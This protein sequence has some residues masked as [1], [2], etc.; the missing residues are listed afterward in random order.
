MEMPDDI[1]ARIGRFQRD[2]DMVRAEITHREL[3]GR[4]TPEWHRLSDEQLATEE[5]WYVKKIDELVEPYESQ[6]ES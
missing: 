1:K 4:S 6:P 3:T 5:A 2:R